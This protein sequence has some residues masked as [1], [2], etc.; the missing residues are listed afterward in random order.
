LQ[1]RAAE[2]GGGGGNGEL[3]L[4]PAFLLCPLS[5]NVKNSDKAE[6]PCPMMTLRDQA[7]ALKPWAVGYDEQ[8]QSIRQQRLQAM[9]A[10]RP[11]SAVFAGPCRE[12]LKVSRCRCMAALTAPH[13]A[14]ASDC[15]RLTRAAGAGRR[16]RGR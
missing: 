13:A 4:P 8:Q 3:G 7:D 14:P 1:R 15:A 16:R 9:R 11:Q 2:D 6:V 10:E 12:G 5:L